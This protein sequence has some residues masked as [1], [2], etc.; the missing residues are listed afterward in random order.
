MK[1]HRILS[2]MLGLLVSATLLFTSCQGDKAE[3]TG[4]TAD[5]AKVM[6]Y[7]SA[8]DAMIVRINVDNFVESAGCNLNGN[9]A[10]LSPAVEK[11]LGSSLSS[12]EQEEFFSIYTL[13]KKC[14]NVNQMYI[15]FEE[16]YTDF[17]E[18]PFIAYAPVEDYDLLRSTLLSFDQIDARSLGDGEIFMSYDN[19]FLYANEEIVCF[20][21]SEDIEGVCIRR[22]RKAASAP[23]EDVSP[24][25]L[26]AFGSENCLAL[27][28]SNEQ[29]LESMANEPEMA[30]IIELQKALYTQINFNTLKGVATIGFNGSDMIFE[31]AYYDNGKRVNLFAAPDINT[32]MLKYL[33]KEQTYLLA[34]TVFADI[35]FSK[36]VKQMPEYRYEPAMYNIVAHYFNKLNG[37]IVLA[38]GPRNEMLSYVSPSMDNWNITL[39]AEFEDGVA[40]ELFEMVATEFDAFVAPMGDDLFI[41]IEDFQAYIGVRENAM[42]VSTTPIDDATG[43]AYAASRF[44]GKNTQFIAELPD[45]NILFKTLGLDNVGVKIEG[46][47]SDEQNIVKLTINYGKKPFVESLIEL[48]YNIAGTFYDEGYYDSYDY[49]SDYDYDD[50]DDCSYEVVEE[51]IDFYDEFVDNVSAEYF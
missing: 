51:D 42:I 29:F 37:S 44:T 18:M 28:I 8:N 22:D 31:T 12:Y 27:Y 30:Q 36:V 13:I 40:Q 11:L 38:A 10:Q 5:A 46:S 33:S 50:Y 3:Q 49:D 2:V 48:V 47:G 25:V 20:T 15:V 6:K 4:N 34:T 9:K 23:L 21:I 45:N 7:L 41:E 17:E 32:G 35:D 16:L 26:K 39:L 43:C 14:I 19:E 1:A 24:D